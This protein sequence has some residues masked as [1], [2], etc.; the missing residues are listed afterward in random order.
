MSDDLEGGGYI[1]LEEQ[2]LKDLKKLCKET[3]KKI[4]QDKET[5]DTTKDNIQKYRLVT[6]A[7]KL[8]NTANDAISK[9]EFQLKMLR[10]TTADVRSKLHKDLDALKT[11]QTEARSKYF[12][13]EEKKNEFVTIG[14][15]GG[16]SAS[17][18]GGKD[19]DDHF[20]RNYNVANLEQLR[21]ADNNLGNIM[22][23]GHEA[24][25]NM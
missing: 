7:E 21:E 18:F 23:M 8:M 19:Q 9:Y 13:M 12:K 25:G 11:S 16:G 24:V 5:F 14:K 15:I 10:G 4:G 17:I 2:S 22:K 1:S 6:N 20:I 3:F